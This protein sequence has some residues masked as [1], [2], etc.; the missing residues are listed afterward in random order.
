MRTV[1]AAFYGGPFDGEIMHWPA[2]ETLDWGLLITP[3]HDPGVRA[4]YLLH[5]IR[6]DAER[7]ARYVYDGCIPA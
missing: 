3:D 4:V 5:S 2:S 6:L 1:A 7:C